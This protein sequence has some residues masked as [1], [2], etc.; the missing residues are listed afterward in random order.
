MEPNEKAA[1]G[2]PATPIRSSVRVKEAREAGTDLLGY[3]G[4]RAAREGVVADY[5]AVVAEWLG[6]EVA[7]DGEEQG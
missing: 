6:E 3:L 4:G 7:A 5:E 1:A 2:R